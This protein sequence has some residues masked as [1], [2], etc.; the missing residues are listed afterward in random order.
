MYSIIGLSIAGGLLA[1]GIVAIVISGIRGIT[2]GKQDF[3][4]MGMFLVPFIVFGVAYLMTED[5]TEA[6][7]A[8]MLF[9]MAFMALGILATGFRST[10]T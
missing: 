9:M 3:K 10:F 7:I 2:T 6:G 1:I 4:K 5:F 8:T